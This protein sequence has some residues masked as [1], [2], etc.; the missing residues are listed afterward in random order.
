MTLKPPPKRSP[1]PKSGELRSRSVLRIMVCRSK[2]RAPFRRVIFGEALLRRN[3][4]GS[5]NVRQ[6]MPA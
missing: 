2:S 3:S 1:L 4:P 6:S 5:C